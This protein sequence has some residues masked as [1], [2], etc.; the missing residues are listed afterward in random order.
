MGLFDSIMSTGNQYNET[1]QNQMNQIWDAYN[2]G[3]IT[4]EQASTNAAMLEKGSI[5]GMT[6]STF[7][8]VAGQMGAALTPK[9]SWQNALGGA[10]A[11]FGS[12]KLAQLA[13][14]EKE[15]RM[16]ELLKQIMGQAKTSD[17]AKVIDP[18]S[19][20]GTPIATQFGETAGRYSVGKDL[21]PLSVN[22]SFKGV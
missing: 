11:Q 10:A 22:P 3:K 19:P 9:G 8:S 16:T 5:M 14:A 15:K 12:Q 13:T 1:N 2:T 20:V 6:P 7:A 21:A 4:P 17:I 18:N